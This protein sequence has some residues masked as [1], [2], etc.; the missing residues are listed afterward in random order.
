MQ[1][2]RSVLVREGAI[3]D[4]NVICKDLKLSGRALVISD[5]TTYRI[6][7]KTVSEILLEEHE[8]EVE[9]IKDAT[10]WEVDRVLQKAREVGVTFVLGVGGGRVIDVAKLVAK[11]GEMEFLSVPTAASHDGIASSRASLKGSGSEAT[12]SVAARAPLGVIADIEIIRKSPYRLTASGCGDIIAKYTAVRD[13]E[14]A[15]DHNGE[16]Y[17]E[18]ASALSLMSAKI[19]ADSSKSISD[20]SETSIRKVVKALISCGVAMSIAGSSRPGSGSEHKFSHALDAIALKPALHGEQCGVGT[21][22]M[23]KL[24][25]GDWEHMRTVLEDIGAPVDAEGLGIEPELV[26]EALMMAHKIREDRYTI[27]G[28]GLSR[29]EAIELASS[30]MVI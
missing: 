12:A 4:V 7:G 6:A 27:L 14:L 20:G 28:D 11:R 17:S 19:I 1:L 5:D 23:T 24:Q 2:P 9:K 16:D 18:Y 22:M 8:V 30:T 10:F 26:I 29:S 21:I 3:E 13:W 25:G 15:R